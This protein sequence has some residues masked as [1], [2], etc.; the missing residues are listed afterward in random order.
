[1]FSFKN[2]NCSTSPLRIPQCVTYQAHTSAV[3]SHFGFLQRILRKHLL[4][5]LTEKE[6]PSCSR[7]G[8]ALYIF[9]P[10][11]LT[12]CNIPR[13]ETQRQTAKRWHWKLKQLKQPMWS[14]NYDFFLAFHYNCGL[15]S[16]QLPTLLLVIKWKLAPAQTAKNENLSRRIIHKLTWIFE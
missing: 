2:S 16:L 10:G 4:E 9:S 14:A 15:Q 8:V 11:R 12:D 5:R 7:N 1:M 6:T 13:I 3:L